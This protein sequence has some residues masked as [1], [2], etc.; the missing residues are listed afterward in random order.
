MSF[1]EDDDDVDDKN[2]TDTRALD[3]NDV[4]VF[5][6]AVYEEDDAEADEIYA[7]VEQRMTSRRQKQREEK[8][9]AELKKYSDAN[10]TVRQQFADLKAQLKTVSTDE[11]A[12]MPDIGDRSIKKQRVERFTPVPDSVLAASGGQNVGGYIATESDGEEEDGTDLAAIGQ[13]RSG[14]LG[15]NLDRAGDIVGEKAS[16]DADK[17]LCE[18]GGMKDV[19][20]SEIGDVKRARRLLECITETNARHGPGWIA[21]ARLE[22]TVGKMSAARLKILEGCRRC[23]KDAEVWLEAARLHSRKTGRRLLAQAVKHVGLV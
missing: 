14:V 9:Q 7:Q 13:G 19:R 20:S 2:P 3:D 6:D 11:W 18:L 4:A 10:P 8:L 22:E 15:Q 23:A 16:V 17:Y 5:A 21:A 1:D 12:S